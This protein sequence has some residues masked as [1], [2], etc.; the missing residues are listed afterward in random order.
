M[1]FANPKFGIFAIALSNIANAYTV[2]L[3]ISYD[4]YTE[5]YAP[6][7]YGT[8]PVTRIKTLV[9][10]ANAYYTRQN[11]PIT[12]KANVITRQFNGQNAYP[13]FV[14]ERISQ[15]SLAKLSSYTNSMALRTAFSADY[16]V[17]FTMNTGGPYDGVAYVQ[18]STGNIQNTFSTNSIVDIFDEYAF[19]HELGHNFGLLHSKRQDP[20]GI[21]AYSY[22]RG[23][24]VDYS[25]ATIMAY[26]SAFNTS[27]TITYFSEP[28]RTLPN[29]GVIG[30]SNSNATQALKNISQYVATSGEKCPSYFKGTST[31]C[32][33]YRFAAN[34]KYTS[35]GT[36]VVKAINGS[37][38][39]EY[40]IYTD[41]STSNSARTN[42]TMEIIV[43]L[44]VQNAWI[45]NG[46]LRT[47]KIPD[48][49]AGK[50]YR[51]EMDH[52]S[53]YCGA[54]AL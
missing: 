43:Y 18:D 51:F 10:R 7:I 35:N 11:I 27:N 24:G 41:S 25:F 39:N 52:N 53:A 54:K 31:N 46:V 4:E 29:Y 12:L 13:D 19:A 42:I 1:K 26:P 6:V 21:G 50:A 16:R 2:E 22:G 14:G 17:H 34:L 33:P 9:S 48:V 44:F 47:C 3:A 8:T 20:N 40:F 45:P 32:A 38:T 49:S 28:G 30:D 5:K 37:N 23:F 36:N 15:E